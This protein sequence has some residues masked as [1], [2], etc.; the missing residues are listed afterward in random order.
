MN[1]AFLLFG[2]VVL[3]GCSAATR[4]T[5]PDGLEV[6]TI[7]LDSTNAHLVVKGGAA[8]L[9][10]SGYEG[11]AQ[12]LVA[13]IRQAG[14]DPATQL[15][16]IV[17]SHGH[18]DHAGGARVLQQQFKVP[19]FV[20]QGDETMFGTG[21][22]EPLCPVGFIAR[23][24]HAQDE[25]ATYTGGTADVLVEDVLDLKDATGLDARV[26]RL[27]G[28]T[29][30]SLIVTVGDVVLVGDL[31]RGSVIG[32]GAET[33]FFMCDLEDNRRGIARVLTELAPDAKLFFVGHFGP[34]TSEAVRERFVESQ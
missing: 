14:I 7:A 4:F 24:R 17:V 32:S 15:K 5:R 8:L 33:H 23:T 10:D 28:H 11:N 13:E 25:G 19:V 16:A 26:R 12:K 31:L 22:N 3:S 18:A 21:K 9:V 2:L 20:G 6:V 27:P 1:N 30:G 29:R 34:V